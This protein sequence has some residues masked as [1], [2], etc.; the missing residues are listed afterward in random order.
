MSAFIGSVMKLVFLFLSLVASALAAEPVFRAGVSAIDI[1]PQGYPRIIAGGFLEGKGTKLTDALHVRC[2]VLDDGVTKI[3]FAIVD[4]CMMEQS[5]IDEAKGLAS[6]ECGIPMDHMMVSATHTHS[7]PAAMGCLGT[8]KDT[9]YGQYLIPKIAEGIVAA[10]KALKP[11]RIGWGSFDDWEHT[12]NRRWIRLLG[13]EV[14]DPFG[15][16]TGRANMHPGYLSKDVVGPSGP[17]DPQLSVIALQTLDG[18]ALGVLANYSQHYFGSAPVS[19]DYFGLFCKH[20]AAKMGQQG[21]GNGPFVCAMSQGTSGDQ[22]WMDYGAEK[23]TTTID[24]YASEVADS[25]M[26]ALQAVEYHDHVPLGMV[27]KTLE[28]KYR[29]PDEARLAWAR[30]IAAKIENDVPKTKEEVYARE[31]L[32]LHERQKTNVRLQAI[33]IGDLSIA[34]LPNEVYAITGLKLRAKSPFSM[35]FNIELANGAEGYI[36]PEEQHLLGG[37]T[38]WPARTAGLSES[39][40]ADIRETLSELIKDL[41]PD[42]VGGLS[43]GASRY[44]LRAISSGAAAHLDFQDY[45]RGIELDGAIAATDAVF[46]VRSPYALWLPGL[47]AGRGYGDECALRADGYVYAQ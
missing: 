24:Q 1:S 4:T 39:A 2:F 16:A 18:K 29:V 34:T 11:A 37:Y 20:L 19:A 23:K 8:R 7:A 31:A 43:I 35:H 42:I 21:D 5:L 28:L 15:N 46:S 38:T 45:G 17:V 47:G 44:L 40:E 13:K 26:K 9:V 27:E 36:P 41:K 10:N 3:A 32:I 33:R 14:V 6:K 12:H 25:A 30:P 22:M